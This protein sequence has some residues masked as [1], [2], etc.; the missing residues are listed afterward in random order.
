M[1]EICPEK[2]LRA[3]EL[4]LILSVTSLP[5]LFQSIFTLWGYE[6]YYEPYMTDFLMIIQYITS[7]SILLYVI[8][9]QGRKISDFGL[10]FRWKDALISLPLLIV[11][12]LA[13][14]TIVYII[15]IGYYLYTGNVLQ[16]SP[17]NLDFISGNITFLLILSIALNA[18]FEELIF[19]AYMFTELEFLTGSKGMAVL[20]SVLLESACHLYQG[21]WAP[22]IV[23]AGF[24]V[25]SLYYIKSRRI[26]PV[27]IAH[28]LWDFIV[29]AN[30]AYYGG[31]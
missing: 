30:Y 31:P 9:R 19:R 14:F 15:S 17:K 8:F 21:L 6:L 5:A 7:I 20:L 29:I 24:I 25:F 16:M 11:F 26:M 2:K 10:I 3:I 13:N 12:S 4:I 28:M 18:F 1:K 23:S 22:F 27:I